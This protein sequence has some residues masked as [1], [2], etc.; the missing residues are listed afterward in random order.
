[1]PHWGATTNTGE[2]SVAH[3][4]LTSCCEAWYLTGR[5]PKTVCCP[6]TEDPYLNIP[7]LPLSYFLPHFTDSSCSHL[8][9]FLLI[10]QF[11]CCSARKAL[12]CFTSPPVLTHVEFYRAT[13]LLNT[14]YRLILPKYIFPDL[15]SFEPWTLC[16]YIM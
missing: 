9:W 2:A 13:Q 4:P 10:V 3:R 7:P 1:M 6:G 8:C 11:K 5:G 12:L 16:L 15:I 14:L